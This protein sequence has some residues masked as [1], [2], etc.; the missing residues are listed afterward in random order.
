M[1]ARSI[2]KLLIAMEPGLNGIE[3]V[4]G[5]TRH[6]IMLY[7]AISGL[8][9]PTQRHSNEIRPPLLSSS[10]CL[11]IGRSVNVGLH[12]SSGTGASSPWIKGGFVY[13]S[14]E[15]SKHRHIKMKFHSQ[16]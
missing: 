16:P 9:S 3:L 14:K 13:M 7:Q 4:D 11:M 2:N 1:E 8:G 12:P 10:S 6:V 5:G 15:R